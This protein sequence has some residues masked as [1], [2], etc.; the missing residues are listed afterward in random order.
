MFK[1]RRPSGRRLLLL[2]FCV[3]AA[4]AA[5]VHAMEKPR[6]GH[7]QAMFGAGCFWGVEKI[8]AAV[9]GVIGTKVGYAG[10]TVADPGYEEVCSG[11]TGHAEVVHLTFDPSVVSYTDL[12]EVFWKY[13]D[14]TTRDRQGPDIGSQ[15]RSIIFT[16]TPEQDRLAKAAVRVL[17]RSGVYGAPVVTEVVPAS[18]FYP[19]EDYHQKYLKKNPG[20]YCSHRLRNPNLGALLRKGLE[21][22]GIPAEKPKTG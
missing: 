1:S 6:S 11:L 4:V 13:H 21:A 18:P 5:G 19:A 3:S 16:Y 7:E 20:G 8:L 2:A 22:E 15:Y 10:G 17:D 12:L 9:P 14:P